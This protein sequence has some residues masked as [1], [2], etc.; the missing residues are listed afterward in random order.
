MLK[1]KS[2]KNLPIQIKKLFMNATEIEKN[3]AFLYFSS[4][5]LSGF[6]RKRIHVSFGQPKYSIMNT[7]YPNDSLLFESLL[8][9]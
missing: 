7:S 1:N 6:Y 5:G 3:K 4:L 2:S 8:K 9:S